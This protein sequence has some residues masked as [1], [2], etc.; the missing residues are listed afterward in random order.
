MKLLDRHIGQTVLLAM[1]V[2]LGIVVALDL[3]FSLV[4]ELGEAGV[5]Y[6]SGNAALFVLLT[7]PTG[8]YEL[9]PYAALGGALI[10]L[11]ILASNNELVRTK[12]LVKNA[13]VQIDATCAAAVS[14]A[15]AASAYH[16]R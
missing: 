9:L 12:T 2:V 15:R 1:I 3:I 8:V 6:H 7:A 4:D 11:G 14:L 10:G 5:D 13:I 16:S